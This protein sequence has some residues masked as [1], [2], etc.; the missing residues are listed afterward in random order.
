[1]SAQAT[2]HSICPVFNHS[3]TTAMTTLWE[4]WQSC[5]ALPGK[6]DLQ[7]CLQTWWQRSWRHGHV[8]PNPASLRLL[9]ILDEDGGAHM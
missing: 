2:P 9:T 6:L 4:P 3:L 5:T 1:M 8:C 7:H